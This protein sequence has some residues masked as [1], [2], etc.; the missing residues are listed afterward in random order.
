MQLEEARQ[1][2]TDEQGID[3][4]PPMRPLV[5]VLR[6]AKE[7]KE[8]DFQAQWRQMKQGAGYFKR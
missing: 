1:Q 7:K 4:G 8:E 2:S 5:E 6:E 3:T